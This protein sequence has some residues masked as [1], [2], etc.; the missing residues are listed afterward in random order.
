MKPNFSFHLQII[1]NGICEML[2]L[3][4]TVG[5]SVTSNY[6]SVDRFDLKIDHTQNMHMRIE[7]RERQPSYADDN[8]ILKQR[9][10]VRSCW[11]CITLV[12][13]YDQ[14]TF[15]IEIIK[16]LVIQ[17]LEMKRTFS[18]PSSKLLPAT[19]KHRSSDHARYIKS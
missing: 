3:N 11:L 7:S 2:T 13:N 16:F 4:N 18:P 19:I 10:V 6:L 14:Y 17:K 5:N 12:N 9:Y 15:L 8:R 1:T